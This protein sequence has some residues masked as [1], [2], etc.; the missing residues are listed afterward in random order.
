M[1]QLQDVT[2]L[3][4]SGE[5]SVRA[6]NNLSFTCPRGAFWAIMGPSGCGKS[7]ILHLIAGLTAPTSGAIRVDGLDV[8]KMNAAETAALR[9]RQIGY[10]MQT[11]NLLPFLTVEENVS[12]PLVLDGLKDRDCRT[13]AEAAMELV[14]IN[15]R[16]AHYPSH[17]SGGEQQRVAIARALVIEPSIVLADEPTGNLDQTNGRAIMDLIQDLNEHTGVTVLLVT[18][19][20]VFAACA[21]R[22]LRLVDGTLQQSMNLAGA[23]AAARDGIRVVR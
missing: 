17:L 10:V 20:P 5:T 21:Q 1:I 11:F 23:D 14:N 8:A 16:A 2:K 4:G 19:D 7:T 6:V 12:F 18:H 13:R 22:V 15:H 9:R 3:F